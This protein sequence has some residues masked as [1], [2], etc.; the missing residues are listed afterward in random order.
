[1]RRWWCSSTGSKA[2][3]QPLRRRPD[4][5][6][7]AARL[8]RRGAA[9][10]RLL[11]RTEPPAA[12][13]PLGRLGRDRLDPAPPAR[14][15][16]QRSLFAAGVSLGGNA[17][18]KWAGEQELRRRRDR[19]GPRRS[20]RRSTLPPPVGP[21]ARLQPGLCQALPAHAEG[22]AGAKLERFPASS[23]RRACRRREPPRVRR[24]VTAP[25]HGF[26]D[27][28]DYWRSASSKPWLAA[29]RLPALVLN[30]AERS[31]PAAAGIARPAMSCRLGDARNIPRAAAMSASSAAPVPGRLDWLPQRLLAHFDTLR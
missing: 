19:A 18:L 3:R 31:L 29:I 9:F 20:A 6:A 16:P 28:A 7:A 12:R 11:G 30:A 1:M 22:P 10:P 8:G 15:F 23:T 5:C 27:A 26:R 13:L 17:L 21:A 2:A 25:L 24:R 14:R 4:A